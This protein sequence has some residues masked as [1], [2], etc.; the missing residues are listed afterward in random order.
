MK[1]LI[2]S[3]YHPNSTAEWFYPIW[4]ANTFQYSNPEQVVVVADSGAR[5]PVEYEAIQW[6]AMNGDLGHVYDLLSQRKDYAFCGWSMTVCITALL[7]Y[8]N[9]CDYIHKEQDCLAFGPW[10]EQLYEESKGKEV[11]TG[12]AEGIICAQS[13]FWIRHRFI[14][15]FVR[16][17]LG[18]GDE[19]LEEN[20]GEVKFK[21]LEEKYPSDFGRYSFGYDRERPIRYDHVFYAQKLTP[22]ELLELRSKRLVSFDGEPPQ[23]HAFTGDIKSHMP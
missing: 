8:F 6:L 19:R 10:V 2:G 3:G 21:R 7:A 16:M 13:L 5:S 12:K 17:Y 22:A 23:T 4:A 15:E 20:L 9:E 14:P 11:L 18:T 1:Y